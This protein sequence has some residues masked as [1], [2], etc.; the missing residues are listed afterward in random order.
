MLYWLESWYIFED[1]GSSAL[2][3]QL[4]TVCRWCAS[5]AEKDLTDAGLCALVKQWCRG[6]LQLTER[7]DGT[8]ELDLLEIHF[9]D[10]CLFDDPGPDNVS[11]SLK[12][13]LSDPPV[14]H[15]AYSTC[16][17]SLFRICDY[18]SRPGSVSPRGAISA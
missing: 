18:W 3:Q 2:Q 10:P 15:P 12:F 11:L 9:I 14:A 6:V 8:L 1:Q 16:L 17:K 13:V 5:R 4:E 7:H